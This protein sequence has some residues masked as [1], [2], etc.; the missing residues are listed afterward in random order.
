M[1][2][3]RTFVATTAGHL[4]FAIVLLF[5]SSSLVC[6]EET[7]GARPYELD[8]AGRDQDDHPPLV[9]FE[10]LSGWTVETRN[11]EARFERTREQQIW[12]RYVGKLTYRATGATPVVRVLPP[13]PIPVPTAVDAV[14]CWIYGN[15]WAWVSDRTTPQVDARLL[16]LDARGKEIVV[17]LGRVRWKEWFLLH[18]RFSPEQTAAASDGLSFSGIEIFGG[19]NREDRVLY[20]DNIAVF[21]ETF[22]PLTFK[23]RP[24]R[25]VPMFAGQSS[26]TNTGPG[27]LPFPT[28][29]DTILP[30]NAASNAKNALKC[31]DGTYIFEYR[32][33]DGRLS[34]RYKPETGTWSDIVAHWEGRG[35]AFKPLYGGGIRL[36]GDRGLPVNVEQC[37][38]LDTQVEDGSVVTKWRMTGDQTTAE[39]TYTLRLLGKSLV[40]DTA[41]GGGVVSE[42]RYGRAAGLPNGRL[43]TLPYYDYGGSRPAVVV[44]GPPDTP[45]FLSGHTD[46]YRS[47]ASQVWADN[48]IEGDTL[49]YQGGVRYLPL[50]DGTRNDCFERFFVTVSPRFDET[51]PTIPNPVSPWKHVT[52]TGVWRAHGASNRESDK[53]HWRKVY[54]HGLR[55]II[56]TDHETGW[57]DGGESFTFRTRTAPGKGGDEGQYEYARFMQDELGFVYGPYNNYTDFAPVNEFW[58]VDLVNRGSDKQLQHAWAR[59]YAPKP[60]RAVE[61]CE[62][63]APRIEEKF[64]FSTAYCDVHTCVTPWSRTDYD[65][66]VPGA[67]TFAATFYAYGEIM[68]LQKRAWDGPVYSEGGKHCFYCGL[69]DGN[70][71]QD[72]GYGLPRNPWLVDFDLLKLHDLC[73]NFGTGNLGMFY[74]RKHDLGGNRQEVDASI[75][76]FLA[77]TIAFGHPGFLVFEGGFHNAMRSYYMTQQLAARYTQA[78]VE[79]IRYVDGEGRQ[80]D[81][82]AAVAHGVVARNQ[83]VCCYD[84]GTVTVANG[85][86]AQTLRTRIEGRDIVL[87]P[88]GYAGW[89]ADGRV[90]MFSGLVDGHRCDYAET[91]EYIYID[92]RGHESRFA[93]AAGSGLA[94]CRVVENGWEVI[95]YEGADCGF[96][97]PAVTAMALDVDGEEIGPAE[98]RRSRGLVFVMPVENAF[99]YRLQKGDPSNAPALAC[100]RTAVIP[101]ETVTVQGRQTHRVTIAAET[102]VGTRIWRKL[103]GAWIDFSTLPAADVTGTLE[104]NQLHVT[105]RS[106]LA[107]ATLA[108]LRVAGLEKELDLAPGKP[109]TAVFDLGTP[110]QEE[111]DILSL[112]ARIGEFPLRK[113]WG[114]ETQPRFTTFNL[115]SAFDAGMSVADQAETT[116][117]GATGAQAE[118]R[119]ELICGDRPRSGIFMHPP[120]RGAAGGYTFARFPSIQLPAEPPAAFRALVG[121]LDGSDIGDGIVFR[122]S[123][124]DTGGVETI[125]AEQEVKTHAW[126]PIEAD[127]SAWAGK[128]IQLKLITDD[129][130]A[131][132]TSGD[133]GA[134]ADLRLQSKSRVLSR[135]MVDGVTPFL[136]EPGP[137]PRPELGSDT[138]RQAKQAWLRY[139]GKGL[140][141]T[142]T[143]ATFA[144]LNGVKL[145]T[146]A[147]AGG[148][149]SEGVFSQPVRVPLSTEAIRSLRGWNCLEIEN[150]NQDCFSIRRFW[151]ELELADGHHCTSDITTATFSQPGTWAYAEGI[152]VPASETLHVGIWFP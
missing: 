128:T 126:I 68:L 3:E 32:G 72:Q 98:L 87:P 21:R 77:A 17:S 40:I 34:Y 49:A 94:V 97:I 84:E 104:G 81:A 50:T 143:H 83:V 42:V 31:E 29:A 52:G 131:G 79:S 53:Q 123:V 70:Y 147:P 115:P 41:A 85:H 23:P 14:T 91:P 60:A 9:D 44:A 59:C 120:W 12:G 118:R 51:L 114:I 27:K 93:R 116:A 150:P 69:T 1:S 6:A 2:L 125:V 37:E 103:E 65:A 86:P 78:S 45:L 15:N 11:A 141:G 73:C 95:P 99:S 36:V 102:E 151:I 145:G 67:G 18:R 140:G 19:R 149:E 146:M 105:M 57:R 136:R 139:E 100:S 43:V 20:F 71:A 110:T 28:R 124:L 39:V 82:S 121:K 13:T 7:V 108:E 25:G 35:P 133:W 54:R 22:A 152:G 61:Y 137:E 76:R 4:S 58:N 63:L 134:W 56:V 96:A 48:A 38:L 109:Q 47:N 101:G 122:V 62:L 5:G 144:V 26:G 135:Q 92:G 24:A 111:A 130:P 106:N 64:H 16:F 89:T 119:S 113:R 10:E 88:T 107:E 55:H 138:W 90:N 142:G 148:I 46:W 30:K 117:M 8:W 132:N 80:L 33:D 66:R 127:L 74:G 75:D 112:D 129:G